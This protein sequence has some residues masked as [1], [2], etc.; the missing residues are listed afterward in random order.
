METLDYWLKWIEKFKKWVFACPD[1]VYSKDRYDI[2]DVPYA[3][4]EALAAHFK[5]PLHD[6]NEKH[7]KWVYIIV[8]HGMS[9][10]H[11]VFQSVQRKFT[12]N[13]LKDE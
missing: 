7:R 10:T 8:E 4:L 3:A 1:H 5:E 13:K 9:E 11:L 12:Y 2:Y 6:E